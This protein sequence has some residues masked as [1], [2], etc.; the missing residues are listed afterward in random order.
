MNHFLNFNLFNLIKASIEKISI[1]K[2]PE[3]LC[4][5]CIYQLNEISEYEIITE[6]DKDSETNIEKNK[7][8]QNENKKDYKS[9]FYLKL[10]MYLTNLLRLQF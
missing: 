5:I 3:G 8:K 2:M 6:I 9:N 4:T 10:K 7:D 1:D